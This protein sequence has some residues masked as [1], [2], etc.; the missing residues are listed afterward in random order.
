MMS[1]CLKCKTTTETVG[2]AKVTLKNGSAAWKGKCSICGTTKFKFLSVFAGKNRERRSPTGTVSGGD[3][4]SS[5]GNLPGFPWAKYP[6]EKHLPRHNYAGPGT[7]LDIRLDE[8]GRPRPGEEPISRVDAAALKHDLA[9]GASDDVRE[10]QKADVELIHDLNEIS[11]PTMGERIT[12]AVVKTAMKG[13]IAV[14]G[15]FAL[16]SPS[17]SHRQLLKGLGLPKF[18]T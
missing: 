1:Y 16:I 7:R 5:L 6:G 3:I 13:K 11:N 17:K 12:R 15:S 18:N 4:Q 14:G 10:R 9:Y 8:N 2:G